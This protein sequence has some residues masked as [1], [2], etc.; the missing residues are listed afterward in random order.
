M[1][2]DNELVKAIQ[3]LSVNYGTGTVFRFVSLRY[4]LQDTG[5]GLFFLQGQLL[6][7]I[8]SRII[9]GR[10]NIGERQIPNTENID[11]VFGALYTSDSPVTALRE[12][13][14]LKNTSIGVMPFPAPPY[15]LIS[16]NYRLQSILDIT[17]RDIQRHLNTSLQELTG[18][19][20]LSLNDNGIAP[21]QALGKVA[22]DLGIQ[23]LKVPSAVGLEPNSFNLV[24]FP[25][26][27]S[28][29]EYIQIYDPS[30]TVNLRLP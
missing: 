25:E 1:L 5:E 17:D 15:I 29:N 23:A 2:N 8:G 14:I 22:Y 4:L 21:T 27:L 30:G 10:Y 19:W 12:V 18:S 24:I 20:K 11:Q 26:N 13:D 7:D 16:L 9:G 3:E 6:S 28:D